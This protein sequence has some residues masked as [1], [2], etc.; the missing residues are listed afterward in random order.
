[1]KLQVIRSYDKSY[2]EKAVNTA[3]EVLNIN[4]VEV[5][6]ESETQNGRFIVWYIAFIFYKEKPKYVDDEEPL[7]E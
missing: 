3:Y 6:T 1:M 2:F 5:T 4:R 7:E